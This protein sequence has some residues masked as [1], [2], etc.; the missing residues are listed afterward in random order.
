MS[1][2]IGDITVDVER[3]HGGPRLVI[4]PAQSFALAA[5]AFVRR[6]PCSCSAYLE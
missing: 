1:D 2:A 6:R 3:L 5:T 4:E